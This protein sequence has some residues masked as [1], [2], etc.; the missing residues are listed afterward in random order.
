MLAG[1]AISG[2]V[3]NAAGQIAKFYIEEAKALQPTLQINP[4]VSVDLIL[5]AGS[6][7]EKKGMTKAQLQKTAWEAS[8][9]ANPQATP[10]PQQA[11]QTQA[12]QTLSG[13]GGQPIAAAHPAETT[14]E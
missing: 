2:G 7:V 10:S 8:A 11:A 13:I 4:G 3:S 6:Y 9:A 14:E 12:K 5:E 1:N